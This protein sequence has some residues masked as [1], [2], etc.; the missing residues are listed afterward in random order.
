MVENL[1]HVAA[2][3]D[4]TTFARIFPWTVLAL[5]LL[6]FAVAMAP[7]ADPAGNMHLEEFAGLPVLH[8]GRIK[9]IDT[10][11]RTSLMTVSDRQTYRDDKGHPQ[12]AIKWL[13][14]VMTS[15]FFE[16]RAG[17]HAEVIRIENDQ[18]LNFLGLKAR[19]G[20]R[21][22]LAEVAPHLKKIEEEAERAQSMDESHRD[23]FAVKIID[24]ARKLHLV[25]RLTEMSEPRTIPP[26]VEGAEWTTLPGA[27]RAMHDSGGHDKAVLTYHQLLSAYAKN[28]SK[29]FNEALAEYRSLVDARMP[30]AADKAGLELFF[31]N[32]E[33]FYQC[34][35][36]YVLVFLLGC[37][38]WMGWSRPLGRA[39]FWLAILTLVVHTWALGARMVIMGRPPVTNLYSSAI[40]IGWAGAVLCLAMEPIFRNGICT[41][42]AA[43]GGALTMLIAHLLAN[44]SGGDT[45]EMLQAVLDTN[46]WLATHVTC[47][48]IGYA[49]TFV[50]GLLGMGFILYN[51]LSWLK[52]SLDRS[53]FKTLGQMTY[54]VVCFATF[55]SFVGTVLGGIWADQSWGR[56]WGWDPKEN[57]ALLIVIWNAL[58]LHARWA[59]MVKLR[60]LA[61]LA[62]LGNIVTSWS[63]FGTNMLGVGLHSYGFMAGA[64]WGLLGAC[65]FFLT[66]AV[67]GL[68]L[69]KR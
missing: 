37:L 52:P 5:G 66:W 42:V 38:S 49:T 25:F 7:P 23:L 68:F 26:A 47:V 35:V 3:A 55:F 62:V 64:F 16:T 65:L 24:L 33:P 53:V 14:D 12:P 48:T 13:L 17:A 6:Y 58:I 51:G 44:S 63:W 40:F 27:V 31:N 9:P 2:A 8:N 34:A 15:Y 67:G 29:A 50:A 61:V 4:D 41:V 56:F 30:K 46:F 39:A 36:M 28:N 11:A 22:S 45:M 54:G 57:G 69:P 43:A 59:G 21:Y 18:V 10:V 32:F 19:P 20:L 1:P 60:G